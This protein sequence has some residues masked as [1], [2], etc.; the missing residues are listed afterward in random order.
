MDVLKL[1]VTV[2]DAPLSFD[3]SDNSAA[4]I[5]G[6]AVQMHI[7]A[8]DSSGNV[9]NMNIG[10]S[11]SVSRTIDS[12]E[13][14]LPSTFTLSGGSA[15]RGINLNRVSGT[16][17]GTVFR[18]AIRGYTTDYTLYTYFQVTGSIEGLVGGTTG[19]GH[20][21]VANDHF[22]ALP[23]S[24][25]CN[26][27]VIVANRATGASDT[28]PKLDAGPHYPGGRCDPTGTQGG[29]PYWNT[30]TRPR[31]ESQSCESGNNNAGI[32]LADGTASR[33]GIVGIGTVVWRFQ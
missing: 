7:D 26:T 5:A 15:V 31:V 29:D 2:P 27:R 9:A 30:G 20:Q 13:T 17:S 22:V 11:T 14:G 32:D 18:L 12:S 8:V 3:A 16:Q 23:V 28:V 25:L 4:V 6:E 19:C 1:R 33:I 24:G 10:V 21:I